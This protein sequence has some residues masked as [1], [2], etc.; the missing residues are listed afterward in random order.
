VALA[1]RGARN[2]DSGPEK[3][4]DPKVLAQVRR[5]AVRVYLKS[6]ALGLALTLAIF[7]LPA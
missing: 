2:M 4:T 7:L 5:Q 1:A 3:I 6:V